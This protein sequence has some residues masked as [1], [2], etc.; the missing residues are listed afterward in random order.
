M[1]RTGILEAVKADPLRWIGDDIA[2]D[3]ENP[4]LITLANPHGK[5]LYVSLA[6]A[7]DRALEIDPYG[8]QRITSAASF[9]YKH[10][11]LCSTDA[12]AWRKWASTLQ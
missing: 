6:Q 9:A 4:A 3:W 5:H 12:A 10:G 2:L 8:L 11:Y 1:E 7:L